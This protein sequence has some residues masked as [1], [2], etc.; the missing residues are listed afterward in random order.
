MIRWTF[1]ELLVIFS[2]PR[3]RP[4]C[5]SSILCASASLSLVEMDGHLIWNRMCISCMLMLSW[6]L[7][8]D[9][10]KKDIKS[11]GCSGVFRMLNATGAVPQAW[12]ARLCVYILRKCYCFFS[13]PSEQERKRYSCSL[14]SVNH[15]IVIYFIYSSCIDKKNLISLF[16]QASR[17][18]LFRFPKEKK[19]EK[20]KRDHLVCVMG[21]SNRP[22]SYECLVLTRSQNSRFWENHINV[23]VLMKW[24]FLFLF[25][26]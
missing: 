15:L 26:K 9:V 25:S 24:I 17:L 13:P 1:V 19:E 2:A 5:H 22:Q 10:E 23:F 8:S 11:L 20:K 14:L 18:L 12:M 3:S 6:R 16:E 4:F 21:W 7:V